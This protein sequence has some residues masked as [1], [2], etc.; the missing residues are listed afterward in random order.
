[1]KRL[2][3]SL[4]ATA[5]LVGSAA[6]QKDVIY[7]PFLTGKGTNVLNLADPKL[8]G[9][10]TGSTVT[11]AWTTGKTGN[12]L[13]GSDHS[14]SGSANPVDTGWKPML[15]GDFTTAWFM[16]QNGAAPG[17]S[18][19]YII[20]NVGSFRCFTGGVASTGLWLRAWGGAPSDLKLTTDIQA[21]AAKTW[22]HVA[23][24]V[25][26][27]GS[28]TATWYVDGKTADVTT[29]TAGASVTGTLN[30]FLGR[31]TSTT[32]SWSYDTD[33][34]RF[35]TRAASPGEIAAWAAMTPGGAGAYNVSQACGGATLDANG[36]PSLGNAKFRMQVTGPKASPVVLSVGSD[37]TLSFDVGA[38]FPSLKGCQWSSTPI[39]FAVSNTG[40]GTGTIAFPIVQNTAYKG[41][42]L[43]NQAL[44]LGQ[45]LANTQATNGLNLFIN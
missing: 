43:W 20:S 18:L 40:A 27:S 21:A 7:Y 24:V 3:T 4:F 13:T 35:S 30:M 38:I 10:I 2:T 12:A 15:N 11:N 28:K 36:A 34:F 25:D 22:V 45:P 14:N 29:L 39:F 17:T 26:W 37:R 9:T 5:L 8:P 33:E 44:V 19:S 42:N 6:A 31:H 23:L 41:I 1:M 32:S 16:K